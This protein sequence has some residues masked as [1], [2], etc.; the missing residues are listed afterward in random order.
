MFHSNKKKQKTKGVM[1]VPIK[2][3]FEESELHRVECKYTMPTDI[4]TV[5]YVEM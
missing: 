4:L 1:K 3:F 5:S 2:C